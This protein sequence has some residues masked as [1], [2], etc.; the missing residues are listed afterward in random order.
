MKTTIYV[1]ADTRK[2][3]PLDTYSEDFICFYPG[4]AME[5]TSGATINSHPSTF[6]TWLKSI[7]VD[8]PIADEA[9]AR[10]FVFDLVKRS[11]RAEHKVNE[12]LQWKHSALNVIPDMQKIGELIGV[13]LGESVSDKIIPWIEKAKEIMF[14]TGHYCKL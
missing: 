5:K 1:V 7:E 11:L 10:T 13:P 2:E 4:G 9:E 14:R 8:Y 3:P 12:L 6:P